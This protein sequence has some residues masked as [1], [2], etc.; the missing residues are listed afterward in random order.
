MGWLRRGQPARAQGGRIDTDVYSGF[1]FGMGV[2]RTVMFRN[3][4]ADHAT[5]SKAISGSP[6]H[7]KEAP[8]EGS[9]SWL[10]E[11]VALPA[12]VTTQQVAD[13]LTRVGLQVER[14][15]VTG[16]EVS[17]PVRGRTRPRIRGRAAEERQG[18]SLVPGGGRRGG[19]TQ[20][21]RLWCAQLRRR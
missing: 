3:N 11:M 12:A 9:M 17:G 16:A 13:A 19:G 20:R 6:V 4:A 14:I 2:D 15:E 18:H 10:R 7:C 8:D 21:H 1:A 5:S